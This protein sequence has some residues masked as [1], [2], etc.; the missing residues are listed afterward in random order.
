MVQVILFISTFVTY[1]CSLAPSITVGDSGEFCAASA[2]LGLAHSPGYPLYA[3]LGKCFIVVL[4]FGSIAYRINILSAVSA[5]ATVSLLY[6]VVVALEPTNGQRR[7]SLAGIVAAALFGVSPAFWHSALQAEVFTLNALFAAGIVAA[8][9]KKKDLLAVFLFGLGLGNHQTLLFLGPLILWACV[10]DRGLTVQRTILGIVLFAAGCSIYLY[11]PVRA[12]KTP[13]L[14]WGNPVTLHNLWRDVSRADYGSLALTTGEKIER[15]FAV[16]G[17]QL[18]R[19]FSALAHQFTFVGLAAGLAGWYFGMKR[20]GKVAVALFVTWGIIG[21]GFMLLANMPFN[22]ETTGILERFYVLANLF[23]VFPVAWLL[24][25]LPRQRDRKR[26]VSVGAAAVLLLTVLRFPAAS[27]RN[28]YLAYDYGKNLFRT[29]APGS[30]FFMDGGDDT[31]Y[32]TAYLQFAAGQRRDIELHDRGGLVFRNIY[33]TDFRK[34]SRDMKDARRHEIEKTFL[35]L[36]PVYYSTFNRDALPGVAL[37]PNGILYRAGG[38]GKPNAFASYALRSIFGPEYD[39]Y[40]SRALAPVYTYFGGLENGTGRLAWWDYTLDRWSDA[41]WLKNNLHVELTQEAFNSFS[42]GR[43]EA[44]EAM[45]MKILSLFPDD[46]GT[47]VNLGVIDEKRGDR[48]KAKEQY[49]RAIAANPQATDA[50]YNL[51]VV[52]WQEG[53]WQEVVRYLSQLLQVN[54]QDARARYYLPQAQ[55]RLEETARK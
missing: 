27:W 10:R 3:L 23:W 37:V 5:A 31:F 26:W 14:D 12:F 21:P 1:L 40:R 4:P 16:S 39:D 33:G 49:E 50:Y 30:I 43:L 6:T 42:A 19:Y 18:V 47:M 55:K 34:L 11:L 17:Q 41:L 7:V 13:A 38:A 9:V 24:Q 29:M 25:E 48:Q 35:P 15:N 32:S 53:H 28:Y 54:P 36:R 22:P 52:Y 51:A 45:Y 20:K 46:T 44:A 2:I 8:V